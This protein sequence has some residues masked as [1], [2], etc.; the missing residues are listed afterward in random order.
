MKQELYQ[1]SISLKEKIE[2][3]KNITVGNVC[4]FVLVGIFSLLTIF[5]NIWVSA[6]IF[7]SYIVLFIYN[8]SEKDRYAKVLFDLGLFIFYLTFEMSVIFNNDPA[9]LNMFLVVFSI[10]LIFYE[11]KVYVNLKQKKYSLKN[12]NPQGKLIAILGSLSVIFGLMGMRLGKWIG[13][14]YKEEGWVV[15][16]GVII[17]SLLFVVSIS[18]L[19]KYAIY[20]VLKRQGHFFG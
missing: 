7:L 13:R 12:K 9:F 3:I 19:Q 11:I 8:R 1:Y 17:V 6:I 14:N 15:G 18:F 2:N 20:K 16:L 4:A 5:I 10:G